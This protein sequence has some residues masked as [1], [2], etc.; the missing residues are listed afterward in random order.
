M[1][2]VEVAMTDEEIIAK[3]AQYRFVAIRDDEYLWHLELDGNRV[4]GNYATFELIAYLRSL[5]VFAEPEVS[6]D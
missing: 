6:D 2:Y 4:Y 1:Y 5:P 3:A